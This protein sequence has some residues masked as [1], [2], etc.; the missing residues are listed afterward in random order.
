MLAVSTPASA[1]SG[2]RAPNRSNSQAGGGRLTAITKSYEHG[3]PARWVSG[4]DDCAASPALSFAQA[5]AP[6]TSCGNFSWFGAYWRN[7]RRSSDHRCRRARSFA[8]RSLSLDP[9]PFRPGPGSVR[10][11]FRDQARSRRR[12]REGAETADRRLEGDVTKAPERR[13]S[14]ERMYAER[15]RPPGSRPVLLLRR[16]VASTPSD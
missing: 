1:S 7:G 15:C 4:E 8:Q 11:V 3:R 2:S 9:F 13:R 12:R 5:K 14:R 16:S 6:I 10:N